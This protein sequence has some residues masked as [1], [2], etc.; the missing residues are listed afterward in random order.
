VD[1]SNDVRRWQ[2]GEHVPKVPLHWDWPYVLVAAG[3]E[4]AL[5]WRTG[6][7]SAVIQA[8]EHHPLIQARR[9]QP[10]VDAKPPERDR[11]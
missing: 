11:D 3:P 6:G 4:Q 9:V 8:L 1:I 7:P 10:D 5:R 2:I